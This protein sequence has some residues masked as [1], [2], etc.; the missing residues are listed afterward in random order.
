MPGL[1]GL[2]TSRKIREI[3]K[4]VPIIIVSYSAKYAVKGY[5]VQAAGY[6][7]KPVSKFDFN[8]LLKKVLDNT[9]YKKNSCVMLESRSEVRKIMT[10]DILYIEIKDHYLSFHLKD[11][12]TIRIRGK[13]SDYAQKLESVNFI[14][15]NECYLVNLLYVKQ[16]DVA[17]NIVYVGDKTLTMSKQKKKAFVDGFTNFL[18][19]NI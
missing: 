17:K 2:E 10:N 3:D 14:R 5:Y 9:K 8:F 11:E 1:D 12:Q 16:I 7:V 4:N 6:L 18:G 13:I 15:C 19:E